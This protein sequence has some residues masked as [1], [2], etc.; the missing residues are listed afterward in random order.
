MDFLSDALNKI[1][2]QIF[3][4]VAHLSTWRT[5]APTPGPR[6]RSI[7]STGTASTSYST[8]LTGAPR[9]ARPDRRTLLRRLNLGQ[10]RRQQAYGPQCD[11]ARLIR[12]TAAHLRVGPIWT[13]QWVHLYISGGAPHLFS[14]GSTVGRFG[15]HPTRQKNWD[16]HNGGNDG[17]GGTLGGKGGAGGNGGTV[18]SVNDNATGGNAGYGGA[19]GIGTPGGNGANG[20]YGTGGNGAGATGTGGNGGSGG[21]RSPRVKSAK[22]IRRPYTTLLYARSDCTRPSNEY[23]CGS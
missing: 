4:S 23:C 16:D 7:D 17:N 13:H 22:L 12:S 18:T 10:S 5:R 20:C 6:P 9:L 2:S 21:V 19:G 14:L 11:G 8:C 15:S 3:A 1:A